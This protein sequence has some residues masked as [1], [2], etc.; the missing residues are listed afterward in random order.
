MHFPALLGLGCAKDGLIISIIVNQICRITHYSLG[1]SVWVT[2]RIVAHD[3]WQES[4]F[5]VV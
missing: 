5:V 2:V 1:Y 4:H 3:Q